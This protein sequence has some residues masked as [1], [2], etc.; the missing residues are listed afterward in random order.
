MRL[1]GYTRISRYGV[2]R[3]GTKV[4]LLTERLL[5]YEELDALSFAE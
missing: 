1:R 2:Q 5:G 3:N 4:T